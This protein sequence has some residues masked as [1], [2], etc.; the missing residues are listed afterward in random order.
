MSRVWATGRE[1]F[2]LM[3][4]SAAKVATSSAA[5]NHASQ[6]TLLLLAHT[7]PFDE[8]RRMPSCK[9]APRTVAKSAS[10]E[11]QSASS[12]VVMRKHLAF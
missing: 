10:I 11:F 4:V 5:I 2:G 1:P 6:V 7:L 12:A 9:N 3:P 8:Q